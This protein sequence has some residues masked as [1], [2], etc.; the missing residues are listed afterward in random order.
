MPSQIRNLSLNSTFSRKSFQ[1][2][3][4]LGDNQR[5]FSQDLGDQDLGRM[6]TYLVIDLHA[7]LQT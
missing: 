6:L 2:A 3:L 5:Y 7:L 1:K 4:F